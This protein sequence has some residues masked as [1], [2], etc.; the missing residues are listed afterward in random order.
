MVLKWKPE[1]HCEY[2]NWDAEKLEA[3]YE[4]LILD[5]TLLWEDEESLRVRSDRKRKCLY[6]HPQSHFWGFEFFF[7]ERRTI[8]ELNAKSFWG[9]WFFCLGFG[10]FFSP[11]SSPTT[12]YNRAMKCLSKESPKPHGLKQSTVNL[13]YCQLGQSLHS[14]V[15]MKL[16]IHGDL[17]L[18]RT[19]AVASAPP[20]PPESLML[21]NWDLT[22]KP[23]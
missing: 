20:V 1:F 16:Y 21:Q 9:G 3:I 23:Q 14:R 13:P 7:Q 11:H 22:V 2:I 10:F 15:N 8:A 17:A 6:K 12:E 5:R 18:L 19:P 4:G